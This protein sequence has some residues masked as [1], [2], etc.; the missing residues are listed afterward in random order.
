MTRGWLRATKFA[1][2]PRLLSATPPI[3]FGTEQAGLQ[4]F[5][6]NNGTKWSCAPLV[7]N[8]SRRSVK[9]AVTRRAYEEVK[10]TIGVATWKP[11]EEDLQVA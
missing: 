10:K 6:I 5:A 9:G 8:P 1:G 3:C 7:W 2:F 11:T 4:Y